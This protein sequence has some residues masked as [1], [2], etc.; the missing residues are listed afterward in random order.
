MKP[1][2]KRVGCDDVYFAIFE[3]ITA[4][5]QNIKVFWNITSP[6]QSMWDLWWIN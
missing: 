3:V 2:H 5:L 1:R 4:V 6:G